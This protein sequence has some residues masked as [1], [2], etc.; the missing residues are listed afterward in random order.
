MISVH[1]NEQRLRSALSDFTRRRGPEAVDRIIRKTV[2]DVISYTVRALNGADA[3]YPHPKRI[4]TGRLRAAWGV[5][6]EAA[7]GRAVGNTNA[8]QPGDGQARWSGAGLARKVWLTNAVEYG[9]YVE[10]GTS[11]MVPGLHLTRGLLLGAKS[12]LLAAKREIPAAWGD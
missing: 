4:D 10:L 8:A 2:F 7:T 1:L 6:S 12:L 3:G 9:P 11:K 5:A